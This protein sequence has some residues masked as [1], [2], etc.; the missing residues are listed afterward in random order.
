M[1]MLL[2][3]WESGGSANPPDYVLLAISNYQMMRY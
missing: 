2:F 3:F 1:V